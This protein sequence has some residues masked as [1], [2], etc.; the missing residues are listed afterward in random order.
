RYNIA[1]RSANTPDVLIRSYYLR[2]SKNLAKDPTLQYVPQT[3]IP[4]LN[5]LI[6]EVNTTLALL[7]NTPAHIAA[8]ISVTAHQA[9]YTSR[10]EIIIRT[11]RVPVTIHGIGQAILTSLA[12]IQTTLDE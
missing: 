6:R 2:Y 9:T 10:I 3:C 8:V 5:R 12:Q 4:R 7:A 11:A 1:P